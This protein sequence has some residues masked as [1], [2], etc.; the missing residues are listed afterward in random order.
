MLAMAQQTS[1]WTQMD[2]AGMPLNTHI[3]RLS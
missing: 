1:A 2:F 3:E